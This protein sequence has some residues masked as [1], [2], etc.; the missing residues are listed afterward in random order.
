MSALLLFGAGA[1]FGSD[2]AG[3]PPLGRKLLPALQRFDPDSWGSLPNA[4]LAH[5]ATDFE[6]GMSRLPADIVPVLQRTMAAYFFEFRPSASNLYLALAQRMAARNWQGALCTLNYDRLLEISLLQA[7]MRP[8]LLQAPAA[9]HAV[10]LC[11]PHGCSHVYCDGPA[12]GPV[13]I[14]AE[15]GEHRRRLLDDALPPVMSYFEP[16]RRAPAGAAFILSQRVRWMVL[17]EEASIVVVVGVRVRSRDGHVWGP[18]GR[19]PGKVVY[20]GGPADVAEYKAWAEKYRPG[21]RDTVLQ[22]FFRGDFERICAEAG[23]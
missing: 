11:L 18:L 21:R 4:S 8:Y 20:C 13:A 5:F 9:A 2:T 7:G 12:D 23:L 16:A 19:T 1:S 22:G 17:S 14:V 15:P 3:T 10:E 6:M